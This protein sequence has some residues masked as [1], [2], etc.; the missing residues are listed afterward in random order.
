MGRPI[1]TRDSYRYE[2]EPVHHRFMPPPHRRSGTCEGRYDK[3][4]ISY[5]LRGSGWSTWDHGQETLL[6]A[7][8]SCLG[9]GVTH[10]RF[11]YIHM[12]EIDE[13]LEWE[14]TFRTLFGP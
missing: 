3:D 9:L 4:D 1:F 11:K 8:K 2:I 13:T 10:W 6:P 7:I 12:P 5:R 14:A